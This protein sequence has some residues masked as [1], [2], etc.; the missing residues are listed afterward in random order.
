MIETV[1]RDR[2]RGVRKKINGPERRGPG[3]TS[4][5]TRRKEGGAEVESRMGGFSRVLKNTTFTLRQ[6]QGERD[7]Y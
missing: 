5:L 6:A 1:Y 4:N 7:R 2:G 3:H